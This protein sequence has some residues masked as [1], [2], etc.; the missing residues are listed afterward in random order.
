MRK[1]AKPAPSPQKASLSEGGGTATA[2]TE[3]VSR[4][5][6]D[7]SLSQLTLTAPSEREPAE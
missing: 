5:G 2:V 6:D 1:P 4:D 7:N 3:G